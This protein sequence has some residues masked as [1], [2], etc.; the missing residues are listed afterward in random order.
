[1]RP[2]P[3]GQPRPRPTLRGWE[4]GRGHIAGLGLYTV[5]HKKTSASFF[6][7]SHSNVLNNSFTAAFS[8]ELQ[9]KA[10]IKSTTSPQICCR[11]TLWC[12]TLKHLIQCKCYAKSLIYRI[13]LP[14]AFS[15]VSCVYADKFKTALHILQNCLPS[16]RT[17]ACVEC[18]PLVNG[19]VSDALLNAAM[20]NV[21]K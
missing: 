16:A 9:K 5:F 1:M 19:C 21:R 6:I 18:T 13:C 3:R 12:A 20:Q 2:K 15:S 8:D 11:T 7:I 10:E 17:H 14:D 4:R